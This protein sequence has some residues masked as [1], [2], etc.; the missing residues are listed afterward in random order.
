MSLFIAAVLAFGLLLV[1]RFQV[2]L[3]SLHRSHDVWLVQL[4]LDFAEIFI[5]R[6]LT[7]CELSHRSHTSRC[8]L[9]RFLESQTEHRSHLL[10]L[11]VELLRI[12]VCNLLIL[13]LPQILSARL[14]SS[15]RLLIRRIVNVIVDSLDIVI[16]PSIYGVI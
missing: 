2:W 6:G 5:L 13:T 1:L 4:L 11:E 10:L 16:V 8:G 3:L 9:V 7:V 15:N 12:G 14:Y